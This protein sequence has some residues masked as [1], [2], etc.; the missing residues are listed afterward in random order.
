MRTSLFAGLKGE[1]LRQSQTLLQAK[2]MTK[3]ATV[4]V[5]YDVHGKPLDYGFDRAYAK[6]HI[7]GAVSV[8][9]L[10]HNAYKTI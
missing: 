9:K 7:A 8:R 3:C 5:A 1:G 4:F 6:N 2:A 10:P